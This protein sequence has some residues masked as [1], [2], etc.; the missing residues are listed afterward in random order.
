LLTDLIQIQRLGEKMRPEN[1]RFRKHL[2]TH[3]YV[4]RRLRHMAAEIEEQIDC[5]ECAN[6]CKVAATPLLERD[7]EKLAKFFRLSI[8]KFTAQYV[9][10]NDEGE[11][12]L[13]R[14]AEG[15]VFLS[16][17]ECTVYEARPSNCVDFPHTVRGE[18]RIHTRMWEFTD[19]AC[20]C[21]IVFN[22]LEAF[23][24]ETGFKR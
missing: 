18:G 6:C 24:Q 9:E 14:T 21:P 8:P 4:E 5:R 23:K 7:I 1:E 13:R 22:T 11:Q 17:N 20:Y 2:K 12:V 19:R 10:T 16:G 3:G 15:C